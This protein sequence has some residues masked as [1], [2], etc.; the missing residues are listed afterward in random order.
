MSKLPETKRSEGAKATKHTKLRLKIQPYLT[1][2]ENDLQSLDYNTNELSINLDDVLTQTSSSDRPT[3][4]GGMF[5]VSTDY[6]RDSLAADTDI[7]DLSS[8]GKGQQFTTYNLV[9]DSS[10]FP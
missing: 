9:N 8:W 10:I 4:A 3:L 5:S 1:N 6:P 7:D 2:S